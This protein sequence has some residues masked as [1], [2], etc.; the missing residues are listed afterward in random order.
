MTTETEKHIRET[1]RFSSVRISVHYHEWRGGAGTVQLWLDELPEWL[2]KRTC[3]VID[4][5]TVLGKIDDKP[6]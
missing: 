4:T 3:T 2:D 6:E 5:I 1:V